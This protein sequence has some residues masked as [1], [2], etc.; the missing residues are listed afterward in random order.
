MAKYTASLLGQNTTPNLTGAMG[1]GFISDGTDQ[2]ERALSANNQALDKAKNLKLEQAKQLRDGIVSGHFSD[3]MAQDVGDSIERLTKLPAFSREYEQVL[4]EANAKLGV[5][6]QKQQKITQQ[7][8]SEQK[9]F[10]SDPSKK[11]YN[12]D[13]LGARIY[14]QLNGGENTDSDGNIVVIDGTGLDTSSEDIQNAVKDFK[15]NINNIKDGEVRLDFQKRLGEIVNKV[16][17]SGGLQNV[18]SEFAK[19]VNTTTGEKFLTGFGKYD[20]KNGMYV[21]NFD[22][23]KLPPMGLVELYRG[24]DDASARLMDHYVDKKREEAGIDPKNFSNAARQNFER[25]FLLEEMRKMAPGGG[26]EVSEEVSFRNRPQDSSNSPSDQEI[27][28]HSVENMVNNLEEL[29]LMNPADTTESS[30]PYVEIDVD[31]TGNT[32]RLLDVSSFNKGDYN[33]ARIVSQSMDGGQ[34]VQYVPPT[35][36]YL[37]IDEGGNRTLIFEGSGP[38]GGPN[39]IYTKYN[40]RTATQFIQNVTK[41]NFGS[42]KYYD[43]WSFKQK[44]NGNM[45][46]DGQQYEGMNNLDRS[47]ASKADAI[48]RLNEASESA[49]TSIDRPAYEDAFGTRKNGDI[50]KALVKFNKHLF[51]TQFSQNGLTDRNGKQ[52]TDRKV[53]FVKF[54]RDGNYVLKDFKNSYGDLEYQV[55]GDD[56]NYGPVQTAS[57]NTSY[58]LDALSGSPGEFDLNKEK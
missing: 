2:L 14:D 54:K 58:M 57:V 25:E 39:K 13:A 51:D 5:Q 15:F 34:K 29:R 33:L 44:Q 23:N 24:I 42:Q 7:I 52:L 49:P 48:E 21:P 56:G 4:A 47:D 10:D 41:S 45:Q 16:Q 46:R 17:D 37:D 28:A 43:A 38:D 50:D 22:E 36:I 1:S 3:I 12:Q 9:A 18:S 31:G 26:R 11:Y 35:K 27:W 53:K 40:G 8:E 55:M 20:S 19:Y 32:R 6:V 30:V